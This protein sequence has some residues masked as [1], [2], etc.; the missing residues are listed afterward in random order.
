MESGSSNVNSP[1]NLTGFLRKRPFHPFGK[2]HSRIQS[3]TPCGHH[4]MIC[5]TRRPKL[6]SLFFCI[7]LYQICTTIVGSPNAISLSTGGSP[8]SQDNVSGWWK[9]IKLALCPSSAQ[10]TVH[11]F[12]H[13]VWSD[14]HIQD[15]LGR[16]QNQTPLGRVPRCM[17]MLWSFLPPHFPSH[18]DNSYT[19]RP[20]V[21]QYGGAAEIGDRST[22]GSFSADSTDW[23]WIWMGS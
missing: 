5:G 11:T 18:Q 22:P 10:D 1:L 4:F 16:A 20:D 9:F 15:K 17:Q 21:V 23:K 3:S 2:C 14:F 12:I 13:Q 19:T 6:S 7:L 8:E